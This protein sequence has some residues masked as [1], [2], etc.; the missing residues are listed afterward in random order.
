MKLVAFLC[1][2]VTTNGFYPAQFTLS[3]AGNR[4]QAENTLEILSTFSS[5]G[6]IS[7]CAMLCYRNSLCRTF[8]F[9]SYSRQCRL[10]EASVDTG[11]IVSSVSTTV[12]GWIEMEPSLFNLYNASSD[13]CV[14]NRFLNS[15]TSSGWCECPIRTFWNGSMCLNQ[16]F[17][18]DSCTND[19]WCRTDLSIHC[20][21]SI[22]VG[23]TF[24]GVFQVKNRS[25][26]ECM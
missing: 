10:F 21:A 19:T 1:L 4:F 22:C 12:V 6:T 26:I 23:K 3:T 16:R 25:F 7:P 5:I 9:D 18:G 15:E 17:D 13:Q 11:T 24:F 20:L 2:L 14:D 8:D